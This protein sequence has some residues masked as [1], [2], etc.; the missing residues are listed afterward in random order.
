[1]L[2]HYVASDNSGKI[3][4]AD[5][6]ADNLSRV[7]QYLAGRDLRPISVKPVKESV[8]NFRRFFGTISIS[9]KIFLTKYLALMLRVGTDLLSAINI[10]ISDFDK[11][12][13]KNFLLEVRD[14]LSRGQQFYKAFESH[15]EAFSQTFVSLIK[16]AETS[17]NLQSTFEELSTS[18]VQ[19]SDL[20]SKIR[21]AFIY[22]IILLSSASGVVVF[23]VTFALPKISQVFV[24]S[25]IKPPFFS[26]LVFS[27]GLF[28]GGNIWIILPLLLAI[29]GFLVYAYFKTEVGK[30]IFYRAL[31]N[32]PIIKEIYKQIA[33]QRLAS[34]MSSLMRAG[35]PIIDTIKVAADTVGLAEFRFSLERIANEG[36]SKGLTIGEAFKREVVFPRAVTNL[37]AISEKAGHLE[38]VLKTLS[39]FYA[40]NIDSSIKSLVSFLEPMLLL[41]MG[42]LVA[43]IALSII[44][45]IYQ[46]ATQF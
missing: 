33:I 36:L 4:E 6:D 35:L 31:S 14:N 17:G 37:I 12:A 20:R 23:L 1:M 46:L 11:P 30:Q 22:P 39:D 8:F 32:T 9:D 5:L 27:V 26:G 29:I 41:M 42:L 28:I 45:P 18:L 13:V 25:G 3:L 2:Y 38:E 24:E 19:E 16:A 15:P 40:A 21:S 34:T 10:L 43:I 44:V 7:L